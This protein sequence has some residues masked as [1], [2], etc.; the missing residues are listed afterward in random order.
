M[1]AGDFNL[2]G[3]LFLSA[4]LALVLDDIVLDGNS[5]WTL[6]NDLDTVCG[7]H[8]ALSCVISDD[9]GLHAVLDRDVVLDGNLVVDANLTV[10]A[11]LVLGSNLELMLVLGQACFFLSAKIKN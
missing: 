2:G 9:L 8:F 5:I 6:V 4:N 3:F 11:N 1:L 7:C 10:G